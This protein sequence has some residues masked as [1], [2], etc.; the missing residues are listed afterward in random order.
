MSSSLLWNLGSTHSTVKNKPDI[1]KTLKFINDI[2]NK[3]PQMVV[4]VTYTQ[5]DHESMNIIIKT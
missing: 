1:I 2:S 3:I 4:H 5:Q